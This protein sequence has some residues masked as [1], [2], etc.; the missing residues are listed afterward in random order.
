LLSEHVKFDLI[1]LRY[2]ELALKA[3][4]TRKVFEQRLLKNIVSACDQMNISCTVDRHFGRMYITTPEIT[5]ASNILQKIFGVHSCSPALATNA[6][7]NSIADKAIGLMEKMIHGQQSFAVRVQRTGEHSFTSLD[8]AREIGQR[9]NNSFPLHVDL[10]NPDIELF[11]E[12]RDKNAYVFTEKIIGP[13]GM[14][15]GTQG[16]ILGHITNTMDLLATWYL[17]KRGCSIIFFI[18]EDYMFKKTNTFLSQWFIPAKLVSYNTSRDLSLEIQHRIA[19]YRCSAV[20]R[21]LSFSNGEEETLE[22]IKLINNS[23]DVPL[24]LPIIGLNREDINKEAD[25]IGLNL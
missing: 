24:L 4:Y 20:V 19:D 18:Q 9:I 25:K 2:G 21:G 5:E 14:P 1:I 8:V 11:I 6:D 22:E 7:M 23:I 15:Q 16:N 17:L 13:G 3:S 10:N 12:I